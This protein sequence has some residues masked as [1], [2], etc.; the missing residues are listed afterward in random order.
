MSLGL[1]EGVL[2]RF[3]FPI[4]LWLSICNDDEF[5]RT[6]AGGKTRS[7]ALFFFFCIII[8]FLLEELIQRVNSLFF[9]FVISFQKDF[10]VQIRQL[11]EV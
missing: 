11:L 2:N 3:V 7:H 6:K 9:S 10:L 1:S 5:L 8:V 4:S